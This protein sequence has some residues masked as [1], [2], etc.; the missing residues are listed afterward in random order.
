MSDRVFK[1]T[2]SPIPFKS[3]Q[4]I[5]IVAFSFIILSLPSKFIF[6]STTIKQLVKPK[7][8]LGQHFLKDEAIARKITDCVTAKSNDIVLEVGPGM[9][10]LS[11]YLA[12]KFND[13]FYLSEVDS[14]S[15]TYLNAHY[16]FNERLLNEDFLKLD[17]NLQWPNQ[18]IVVCGNFPYNISSQIVFKAID[19]C[20]IVT[21]LSG[22]FQKEVAKRICSSPNSKEYGMLSVLS[23]A[24]YECKYQFTVNEGAFNPPPKVK[25]GVIVMQKRT[26]SRISV[27]FKLFKGLVKASFATR[28]KT[29]RNC[30]KMYNFETNHEIENLL[31]K[32]AEQ[33]E[34]E[35]FDFLAKHIVHG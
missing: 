14:E 32:R 35:Q 21:Q 2:S 25:S 23:Q 33:L 4:L 1:S 17:F 24:L 29:L 12:Q 28:R 27:D 9:G 7:K 10:V 19:N 26:I 31:Q 16:A 5:P 30:L 11:K 8:H 13:N 22:M 6:K 15:I 34:V 18:A 20:S 3:P